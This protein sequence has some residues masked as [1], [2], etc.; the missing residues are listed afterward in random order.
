MCLPFDFTTK[1]LCIKNKAVTTTDKRR[2]AAVS[3]LIIVKNE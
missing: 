2:L 1:N 3:Y